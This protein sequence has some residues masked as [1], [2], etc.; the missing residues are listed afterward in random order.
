MAAHQ[1][2]EVVDFRRASG[3]AC[4]TM[5]YSQLG[6]SGGGIAMSAEYDGP[7]DHNRLLSA[8][9][10]A[11]FALLAPHI[12]TT[13]LSKASSLRRRATRLRKFIFLTAA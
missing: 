2:N 7:T 8:L 3:N 10:P 4:L 1:I 13:H 5:R 9:H 6:R 12:K 11:D